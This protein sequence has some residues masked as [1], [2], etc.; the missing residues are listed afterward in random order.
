MYLDYGAYVLA[1]FCG[2]SNNSNGLVGTH[3]YYNTSGILSIFGLLQ[4]FN[5]ND[6]LKYH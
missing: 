2:T 6:I 1:P 4:H 3:K 5:A